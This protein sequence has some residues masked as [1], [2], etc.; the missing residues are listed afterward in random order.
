MIEFSKQYDR[1]TVGR[2]EHVLLDGSFA[3]NAARELT[4]AMLHAAV[5][6]QKVR[7]LRAHV[8]TE[9][10]DVEAVRSVDVLREADAELTAA[11]RRAQSEGRTVRLRVAISIDGEEEVTGRRSG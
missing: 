4:G 11:L 10:P 6:V 5:Q 8:H 9:S 7:N 3:G 1:P 2:S